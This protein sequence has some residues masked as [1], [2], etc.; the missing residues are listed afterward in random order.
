MLQKSREYPQIGHRDVAKVGKNAVALSVTDTHV[1]PRRIKKKK[2]TA[3]C[4]A[5]CPK[6]V[7]CHVKKKEKVT[8]RAIISLVL[9]SNYF[10]FPDKIR[11]RK[12]NRFFF[13]LYV[14]VQDHARDRC[15]F[16]ASQKRRQK[17]SGSFEET[18][19]CRRDN[20]QRLFLKKKYCS[21]DRCN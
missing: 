6:A 7:S 10:F 16:R 8:L 14:R 15:R 18:P 21:R 17:R 5:K 1:L 12:K 4:S 3:T 9:P 19:N 11:F 20:L 2:K 13:F